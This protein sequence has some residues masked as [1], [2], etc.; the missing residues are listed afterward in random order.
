MIS[1]PNFQPASE[2]A[3]PVLCEQLI[4]LSKTAESG[5]NQSHGKILSLV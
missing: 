1:D 4:A 3:F 2:F 5:C